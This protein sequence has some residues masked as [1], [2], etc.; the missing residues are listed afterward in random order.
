MKGGAEQVGL[1]GADH[2]RPRPCL[3][4]GDEAGGL[5][6]LARPEERDGAANSPSHIPPT[7]IAGGFGHQRLP[8]VPSEDES[9]WLRLPCEQRGEIAAGGEP[10]LGRDAESAALVDRHVP[11]SPRTAPAAAAAAHTGEQP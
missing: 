1:D 9:A 4:T 2:G 3:H 5:A 7:R 10:G 6:G 8:A 11:A